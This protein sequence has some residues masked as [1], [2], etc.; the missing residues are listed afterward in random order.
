MAERAPLH[1]IARSKVIESH[2]RHLAQDRELEDA[3]AAELAAAGRDAEE[4]RRAGA[5]ESVE[6]AIEEL[7][8][9]ARRLAA[10]PR[11][12]AAMTD[13]RGAL[14]RESATTLGGLDGSERA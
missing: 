11:A 10:A 12:G 8:A 9:L 2:V 6:A 13:A 14:R 1:L 7:R 3:L 5:K 4:A